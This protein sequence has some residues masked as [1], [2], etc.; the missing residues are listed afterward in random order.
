METDHANVVQNIS[1]WT[2]GRLLQQGDAFRSNSSVPTFLLIQ[3]NT[4]R[5]NVKSLVDIYAMARC[6]LLLHGFSVMSEAV[7]NLNI[8]LHNHSVNLDDPGRMSIQEFR[9]MVSE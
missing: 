8:G 1:G 7:M 6:S 4:Q 2:K 9:A 3:N 5:P